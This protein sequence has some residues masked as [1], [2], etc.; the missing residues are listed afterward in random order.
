ML[1]TKR[2]FITFS[3]ILRSL[4]CWLSRSEYLNVNSWQEKTVRFAGVT[5][6]FH[7][8]CTLNSVTPIP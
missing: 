5:P 6:E 4:R 8:A 2:F 7:G 3:L 1:P